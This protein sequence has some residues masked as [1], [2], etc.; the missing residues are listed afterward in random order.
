[1][2]FETETF[3]TTKICYIYIQ[4]TIS[5]CFRNILGVI[6]NFCTNNLHFC[7][8]FHEPMSVSCILTPHSTFSRS[9]DFTEMWVR[10]ELLSRSGLKVKKWNKHFN[11]SEIN[12]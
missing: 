7:F 11:H 12:V 5:S 3:Q 10:S 4:N 2:E 1:M 8:K 6:C 9:I